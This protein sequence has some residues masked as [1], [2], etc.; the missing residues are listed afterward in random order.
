MRLLFE[1]D[2]VLLGGQSGFF[3][4]SVA[5]SDSDQGSESASE[6]S[7]VSGETSSSAEEEPPATAA[8]PPL[9]PQPK[10]SAS[11]SIKTAAHVEERVLPAAAEATERRRK[12]E[13]A[14]PEAAREPVVPSKT[15]SVAA[16]RAPVSKAEVP[17]LRPPPVKA[18]EVPPKAPS[19]APPLARK[20]V[21]EVTIAA[22]PA[23]PIPP[24]AGD[25]KLAEV[26]EEPDADDDSDIDDS[27]LAGALG[28]M[29]KGPCETATAPPPKAAA[30][31]APT[32]EL[33][34]VPPA[35]EARPPATQ[36]ATVPLLDARPPIRTKARPPPRREDPLVEER[37]AAMDMD[38]SRERPLM[39]KTKAG[40]AWGAPPPL[41]PGSRLQ[42]APDAPVAKEEVPRGP[43]K[44]L[45]A[46]PKVAA[47]P[48]EETAPPPLF[49]QWLACL[50][51]VTGWNDQGS[52][53][54]D[55]VRD[56]LRQHLTEEGIDHT[57]CVAHLTA[58]VVPLLLDLRR[59]DAAV[60]KNLKM[61]VLRGLKVVQV[62]ILRIVTFEL[63]R[64]QDA[65]EALKS[66]R[67]NR[68][69]AGGKAAD[70]ADGNKLGSHAKPYLA[71]DISSLAK[72]VQHFRF[73][74]VFSQGLHQLIL[75]IR[76]QKRAGAPGN[77]AVA[78]G[79]P[80]TAGAKRKEVE[81]PPA[82]GAA[83][84]SDRSPKRRRATGA[85]C[86]AAN[87]DDNCAEAAPLPRKRS[88]TVL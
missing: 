60:V 1:I 8:Q 50:K 17:S 66:Q 9:W 75:S 20:E 21:K 10:S 23:K 19:S 67:K 61:E 45:G 38:A 53:T 30:P 44:G 34:P 62:S 71:S 22:A 83:A 51:F 39:T 6:S 76:R 52:H 86:A 69:Q 37:K 84:N 28:A 31:V 73:D 3:D 42:R 82:G 74:R 85:T 15:K 56:A 35:R 79:Q 25:A 80:A 59:I 36:P 49:D 32:K 27:I 68:K 46:R 5:S 13:T 64:E 7:D 57:Q 12:A 33:R 26:R 11:A 18:A 58:T 40:P 48:K 4:G 72:V 29:L 87:D 41:R 65:K 47:V 14:A 24:S 77:A 70:A 55:Q 43:A 81:K 54:A 63:C 78:P 88:R 2:A 16:V